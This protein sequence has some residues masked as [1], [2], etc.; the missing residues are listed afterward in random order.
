MS[1]KY[2]IV[3]AAAAVALSLGVWSAPA[4]AQASGNITVQN[5][6]RQVVVGGQTYNV[7]ASRTKITIGGK[8]AQRGDLKDGLNC[9]VTAE[10]DAASAISCK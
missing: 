8:D 3:A 1:N 7:S 5:E 6:G 10:G 9:T 2:A 4:S